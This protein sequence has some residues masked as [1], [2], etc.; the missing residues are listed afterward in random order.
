ML[1][2]GA[3]RSR[4]REINGLPDHPN[5]GA[6]LPTGYRHFWQRKQ[7]DPLLVSNGSSW[8]FLSESRIF[9]VKSAIV[10]YI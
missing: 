1:G 10:L 2:S 8:W 5:A 3:G 4:L 9:I 6:S 7:I